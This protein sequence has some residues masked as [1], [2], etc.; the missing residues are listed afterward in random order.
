LDGARLR[1]VE[2]LVRSDASHFI[3]LLCQA[4][5]LLIFL[6]SVALS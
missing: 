3:V 4:R 2:S 5:N 6:I 1:Q